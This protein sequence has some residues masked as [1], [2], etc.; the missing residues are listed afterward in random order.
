[1]SSKPSHISVIRIAMNNKGQSLLEVIVAMAIFALISAAMITL[2]LGGFTALEQG[3]EHTE[4]KALAQE[5]IEAVRAIRDSAWNELIYT[6]SSVS[7]F[8]DTSLSLPN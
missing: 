3:G 5:G 1:M 6:T 7:A 2:S 4:A 8:V